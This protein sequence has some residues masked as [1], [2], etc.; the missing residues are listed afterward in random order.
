M[1]KPIDETMDEWAFGCSELDPQYMLGFH[2]FTLLAE[3]SHL[4]KNAERE[5]LMN[6]RRAGIDDIAMS[7]IYLLY[8][9]QHVGPQGSLCS[10]ARKSGLI[11]RNGL[12]QTLNRLEGF[13]WITLIT[14]PGVTTNDFRSS[15]DFILLEKGH[16]ML[17]MILSL[18]PPF[19]TCFLRSMGYSKFSQ[20]LASII[21]W[22]GEYHTN[23]ATTP[24]V[25]R[26]KKKK[27]TL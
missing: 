14:K 8:E 11:S 21:S 19:F 23:N 27:G 12:K 6:L 1:K 26:P 20:I 18:M 24:V 25:F 16:E 13:G 15:V 3:I 2:F 17:K 7:D 4:K 22:N 9:M 10:F 5:L